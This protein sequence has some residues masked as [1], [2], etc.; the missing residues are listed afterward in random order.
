M[1]FLQFSK[2]K[3]LTLKYLNIDN[4]KDDSL[5]NEIKSNLN[6]LE[7]ITNFKYIYTKMTKL[8]PTLNKQPYLDYLN[9]NSKYYIVASTLGNQID[10][11]ISKLNY[12][13]PT[14]MLIFDACS[15]AYLEVLSDN[16]EK[17]TF[18]EELAYRF[19]PGYQGS[20]IEDI[21][22]LKKY[23]NINKIGIE[24]LD[25]NLMVPSKSLIGI[26]ANV[27][28]NKTCKDCIM[29]NNCKYKSKEANGKCW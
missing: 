8:I 14:K 4:Q 3:K 5:S 19:C 22:E 18:K 13:N 9:G 1:S 25:S 27:K 10:K 21:F 17:E 6:T 26:L 7:E 16:Y 24:V 12:K 2:Y 15:S 29:L 23:L 11:E 28:S 20:K